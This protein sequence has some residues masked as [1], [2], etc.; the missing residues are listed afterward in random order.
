MIAN[1]ISRGRKVFQDGEEPLIP[2]TTGAAT[3]PSTSPVLSTSGGNN[4]PS[5]S[6]TH[7]L[8]PTSSTA[9][10]SASPF[11]HA[12]RRDKKL[13]Q[14]KPSSLVVALIILAIVVLLLFIWNEIS[15][16]DPPDFPQDPNAPF[17]WF[18]IIGTW[19]GGTTS[20]RHYFDLHPDTCMAQTETKMFI[21]R[22]KYRNG[23]RYYRHQ[24][25]QHCTNASGSITPYIGEKSA[26]YLYS[27]GAP[28]RVRTVSPNTKIVMLL[29]NPVDRLYSHWWMGKCKDRIKYP[30]ELY[31]RVSI[32]KHIGIYLPQVQRW[33]KEFPQ[34]QVLVV[35]S[36]KFFQDTK[37]E[38]D[39]IQEFLGV[40]YHDFS[41]TD[42][43]RVFG[44]SPSC[45]KK[46]GARPPIKPETRQKLQAYYE[47]WNERLEKYLHT[48]FHWD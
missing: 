46:L 47:P 36:E 35:Q 21:Y 28:R 1:A 15:D 19:K 25:F 38:L 13:E 27:P 6:A 20:L 32:N 26:G 48:D 30:F 8:L 42:I 34:D 18:L 3:S 31:T 16:P 33:F 11:R 23:L 14:A 12:V 17:P 41:P 9:S 44:S 43:S 40:P 4:A 37:T 2:T 7:L 22:N 5:S 29:R 10:S 45:E 24:Y 39:R